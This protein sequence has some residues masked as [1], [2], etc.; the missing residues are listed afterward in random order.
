MST[1][2]TKPLEGRRIAVAGAG[3]GLG[4]AVCTALV[5]AGAW[6]AAADRSKDLCSPVADVAH[7]THGV[8]L[9]T[10]EGANAWAQELQQV[11]GV[12][13]LVGGWRGG[14]SVEAMDLADLDLLEGLLFHTLVHTTRAFA[15]LLKQ[16]GPNGRF[17][18]VSSNVV[19]RP[20]AGN[21]AYAATKAAA[22]AWTLTLAAELAETDGTANVAVVNA[23]VTPQMREENP[24]K[25]YKT[26]TDTSEIADGLVYL[27]S[28]AARKMNGQRL[29]LHS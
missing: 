9:L 21:A 18:T 12:L 17:A 3:G 4:P 7:V 20:T 27:C 1:S 2:A 26:F 13:H 22:E 29:H 28:D 14:D 11:D 25:A 10:P 15:P 19:A 16:A 8:D 24:D 6:V 5:A 23:I